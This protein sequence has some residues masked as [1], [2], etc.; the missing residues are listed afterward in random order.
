[1]IKLASISLLS[2]TLFSVYLGWGIYVL[3]QRLR[4]DAELSHT[5]EI[6]TL[7]GLAVFYAVEISLLRSVMR[8]TPVLFF[9][10]VLGMIVSSMAL[11]GPMLISLLSHVLVESVMP[12][13]DKD[14]HEPKYGP[15]EAL[16]RQGEYEAALKEYMI[17]ARIFPKDATAA[18]RIADNL[19]KL[20]RPEDAAPWFER[21]LSRLTSP[22]KSLMVAN[23]LFDLYYRDLGREEAGIRVLEAFTLRFPN[24]EQTQYVRQ[25]LESLAAH[26]E[27]V[28]DSSDT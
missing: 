4:H 15:A 23:R 26:A 13:G 16:E 20:G 17:I 9:F 10:A 28:Q 14:L 22:Q 1:M 11:Y 21:G 5:L 18:L 24:A 7:A 3:R 2:V 19:M 12:S 25:R 6:A 27:G 8:D